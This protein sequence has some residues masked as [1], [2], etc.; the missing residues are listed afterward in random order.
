MAKYITPQQFINSTIGKAYDMDGSYGVQCVDGIK[1]FAYDVYGEYKFDCGACGYAYGLWTNYGTNGVEKYFNKHSF[2]EARKGDWIIWNWGSK[3]CAYSHVA[4]FDSMKTSN[5]VNSYGE[6]QNGIKAFNMCPIYTDGIL[7][8]LRPK[9]YEEETLKY[10]AHIQDLGWQDWKSNGATAGTTGKNLRME[11][12]RI[13]SKKDVYAKAHI[14][15]IGWVDYGKITKDTIIGTTG[16]SK[17]LECLCL[18]GNFKYRVHIADVGW[19]TWT[20]ADGICTLGSVGQDLG[21]EA[22]EIIG[23]G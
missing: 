20:L 13:D 9:I 4:M 6:S 15:D 16:Q 3:G 5:V 19:S 12:I 17:R 7:G 18:K 14:Q 1:K 10:Q 22:I 8:V 21:L 23:V 11:A 2:S